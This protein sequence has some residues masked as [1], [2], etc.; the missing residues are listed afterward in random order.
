MWLDARSQKEN[1]TVTSGLK[2]RVEIC[3]EFGRGPLSNY[4]A[5]PANCNLLCNFH[6]GT[7]FVCQLALGMD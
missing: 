3:K 7:L 5:L 4:R 2:F 1:I 6:G